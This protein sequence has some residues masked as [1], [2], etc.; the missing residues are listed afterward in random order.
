MWHID[1]GGEGD[2]DGFERC[3]QP[4]R[5]PV[6]LGEQILASGLDRVT[7]SEILADLAQGA[8]CSLNRR[9]A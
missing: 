1:R 5:Q 3:L 4:A 9:C 8:A 6:A 7:V 2:A